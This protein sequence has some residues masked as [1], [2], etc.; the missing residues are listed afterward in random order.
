MDTFW[1]SFYRAQSNKDGCLLATTISSTAISQL[2]SH[3]NFLQ[4]LNANLS[5]CLRGY[6]VVSAWTDILTACHTFSQAPS[7]PTTRYKAYK[8][9]VSALHRGYSNN[10]LQA[11]TIPC[12]YTAGET[13]RRLALFADTHAPT[14]ALILPESPSEASLPNQNLEDCA[15]QINRLFSLCLSDDS[16]IS[17]SRKWA[18]Y[19]L[20]NLLFKIYFRLN[21]ISLCKNIL[22]SIAVQADELPPLSAFPKSHQVTYNYYTGVLAFLSEDYPLA[23][24]YLSEAHAKCLST[25]TRNLDLIL[26]YLIPTRLLTS[27]RIPSKRLL[28]Q[29]QFLEGLFGPVCDAVRNADPAGFEAA[30]ERGEEVF[31]KQRLHLTLERAKYVLLRNLCRRVF[32]AAPRLENGERRTRVPL[33]EFGAALRVRGAGKAGFDGRDGDE[34]ECLLANLIYRDL[35]KGYIARE[36]GMVVLSR[37]AAFPGTGC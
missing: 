10:A 4:T 8:D 30:L 28:A 6:T 25:S 19:N 9:V 31:V 14:T 11:W 21:R 13:L 15:R 32:L 27:H 37:N 18:L 3:P 5:Q 34:V 36:R 17:S 16:R 29:S 12:L 7:N 33:T 20:A 23:D 24:K 26:M 35:V 2:K 1:A 22:R